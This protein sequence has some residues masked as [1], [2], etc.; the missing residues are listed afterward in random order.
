MS[1]GVRGLRGS[2]VESEKVELRVA[3]QLFNG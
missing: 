2:L 3:N 1:M